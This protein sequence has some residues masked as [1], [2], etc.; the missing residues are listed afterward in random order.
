MSLAKKRAQRILTKVWSRKQSLLVA[1]W[2]AK[3]T[4]STWTFCLMGKTRTRNRMKQL[5]A[6]KGG[7]SLVYTWF[8]WCVAG[9]WMVKRLQLPGHMGTRWK[10][11]EE[12]SWHRISLASYSWNSQ[13]ILWLHSEQ[14]VAFGAGLATR[15]SDLYL[16]LP[17]MTQISRGTVPVGVWKRRRGM[18]PNHSH[19]GRMKNYKMVMP[20]FWMT[21]LKA[22][23]SNN[24]PVARFCLSGVPDLYFS[25]N[26]GEMSESKRIFF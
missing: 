17:R 21:I 19:M 6:R 1:S 20:A 12:G 4:G 22:K 25:P 23:I 3:G 16:T 24:V 18:L 11:F 15:R 5:W 26:S 8:T 14:P 10:A 9:F 13:D 7:C 2:K